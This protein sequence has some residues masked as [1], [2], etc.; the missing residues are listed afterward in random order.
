[1]FLN[2]EQIRYFGL[3]E[4]LYIIGAMNTSDRSVV[5]IDIDL[6]RRFAFIRV[7]LCWLVRTN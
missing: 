5:Q 2:G 6:R 1:M 3:P 7:V 4:N